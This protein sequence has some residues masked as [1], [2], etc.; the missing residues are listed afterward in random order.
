M[1]DEPETESGN[2]QGGWDEEILGGK[3]RKG[4]R[5]LNIRGGGEEHP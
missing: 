4:H 5:F 1:S 3:S 2:P